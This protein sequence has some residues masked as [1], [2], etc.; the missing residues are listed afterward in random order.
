MIYEASPGYYYQTTKKGSK[1]IDR[2]KYLKANLSPVTLK[3]GDKVRVIVKP[4]KNGKIIEGKI[5]K[6]LTKKKIHPRGRKVMLED[7]TVGRL[8]EK[9]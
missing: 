8:I 1:R 9:I 6:I 4:Y 3:K 2:K 7:G 5:K